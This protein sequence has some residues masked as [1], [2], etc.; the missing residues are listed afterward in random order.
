MNTE[1]PSRIPTIKTTQNN[2]TTNINTNS[3]SL[4]ESFQKNALDAINNAVSILKSLTEKVTDFLNTK[5]LGS[6]PKE[7]KKKDDNTKKDSQQ[8]VITNVVTE[9][10]SILKR[11]T[12]MVGDF[13]HRSTDD[14]ENDSE[15]EDSTEKTDRIAFRKFMKDG[16]SKLRASWNK[17]IKDLQGSVAQSAMLIGSGVGRVF[18]SG[19]FGNMISKV[20]TKALSFAVSKV[21]IGF[22]VANLPWVAIGAAILAAIYLIVKYA[23]QIWEGIKWVGYAIDQGI[24]AILDV[25]PWG[26]SKYE[27]SR[28]EMAAKLGV[29]EDAI[30]DYYG[31]TVRG[32]NQAYEDW[33]KM[34]LDDDFRREMTEKIT[35]K[36]GW[37]GK[38]D[39]T[40][41]TLANE[42]MTTKLVREIQYAVGD[43]SKDYLYGQNTPP[44]SDILGMGLNK[45]EVYP[46]TPI[47]N[48]TENNTIINS[49]FGANI[50]TAAAMEPLPW[51]NSDLGIGGSSRI[52]ADFWN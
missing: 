37:I 7:D 25:L 10:V 24:D 26:K 8:G 21:L 20:I 42:S 23:D 40:P 19:V 22:V 12:N 18:G 36:S 41:E 3:T 17:G 31:D 30:K 33:K 11:F 13:F 46:M 2:S 16:I 49:G 32:R 27:K 9:G 51:Y 35:K 48:N 1:F 43:H 47:F 38:M 6:K 34:Q 29:S 28:Q 52:P 50:N 4:S 39:M 14:D 44:D 15:K 5:I 45:K